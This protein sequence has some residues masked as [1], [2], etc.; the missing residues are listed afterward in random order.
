MNAAEI[1]S[2]AG[3]KLKISEKLLEALRDEYTSSGRAQVSVD[4]TS[5]H[6]ATSGGGGGGV[7]ISAIQ[8][9]EKT[10]DLEIDA[11]KKKVE[12]AEK[13]AEDYEKII[14]KTQRDAKEAR[15]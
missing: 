2:I 5:V 11:L 14:L 1:D 12:D 3:D 15:E 10:K 4:S 8:Q 7:S 13:K 6:V 9:S